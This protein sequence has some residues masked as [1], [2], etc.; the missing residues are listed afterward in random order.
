M[1]W[2]FRKPIS[3]NIFQVCVPYRVKEPGF[4]GGTQ[5]NLKQKAFGSVSCFL[6][7]KTDGAHISAMLTVQSQRTGVSQR[8]LKQR[9]FGALVHFVEKT[10]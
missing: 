2:V 10:W 7:E 5:R 9:S 8:Y 1:V 3:I 4:L 6:F